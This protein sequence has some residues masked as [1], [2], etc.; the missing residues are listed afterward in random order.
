M[1]GKLQVNHLLQGRP[2]LI[3]D[4]GVLGLGA[5]VLGHAHLM[6]LPQGLQV[7]D[8]GLPIWQHQK[9][10]E[11]VVLW[12]PDP[13]YLLAR[14]LAA[15]H[16]PP[17]QPRLLVE[18]ADLLGMLLEEELEES[19]GRANEHVMEWVWGKEEEHLLPPHHV[20]QPDAAPLDTVV[21]GRPLPVPQ[22][23]LVVGADAGRGPRLAV[24]PLVATVIKINVR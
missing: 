12:P 17:Q 13:L 7:A 21:L 3:K 14:A 11:V 2:K 5:Q 23:G 22:A 19:V 9:L 1:I 20:G 4:L 18:L 16:G 15:V 24:L 10:L 6:D 8:N